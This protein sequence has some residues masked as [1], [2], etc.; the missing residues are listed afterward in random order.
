[1]VR[2]LVGFGSVAV[3]RIG[4]KTGPGTPRAFSKSGDTPEDSQRFNANP[5][6]TS[7]KSVG[8]LPQGAAAPQQVECCGSQQA[9]YHAAS[10][11]ESGFL[12]QL[13]ADV[14]WFVVW[15]MH[16]LYPALLAQPDDLDLTPISLDRSFGCVYPMFAGCC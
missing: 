6:C 15:P 14:G 9:R 13:H 4:G 11:V 2:L 1:M 5:L 16:S 10:T 12:Q 3:G 8:G 7:G